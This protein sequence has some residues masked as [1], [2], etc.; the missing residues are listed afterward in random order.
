MTSSAFLE[1]S[2]SLTIQ[3]TVVL[4]IWVPVDD[5][6]TGRTIFS[7]W[8]QISASALREF[9]VAVRTCEV[10]NHRLMEDIHRREGL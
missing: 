8:P 9:G 2:L 10:D 3:C 1:V 7:P 4:L 6:A 5:S